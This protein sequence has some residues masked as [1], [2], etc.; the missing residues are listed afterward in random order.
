[1]KNAIL[2][3]ILGFLIGPILVVV[4]VI[5]LLDRPIVYQSWTTKECIMVDDPEGRYSCKD[6]P[7][8]AFQVWVR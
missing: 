2:D 5:T 4:L 6:L 8:S 1:M 3:L 7:P